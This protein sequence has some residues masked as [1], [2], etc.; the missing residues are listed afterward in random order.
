MFIAASHW[1]RKYLAS[2]GVVAACA[3]LGEA[4]HILGLANAN[5]IMIFLTAVVIVAA[6]FG[7]GPATA[8]A[9]LGVLTFDFF[10]VDPIFSF[11]PSD[12]QYF[13]DLGVMLGTGLL[14]SELTS[15]LKAQ[16]EVARQQEHRTSQLYLLTRR[17]NDLAGTHELVAGTMRHLEETYGGE[18]ALLV[19]DADGAIRPGFGASNSFVADAETEQAA[20]W[21]LERNSPAGP[22]TA[23]FVGIPALLVPMIGSRST[24][25]VLRIRPQ[26]PTR[27]LDADE[28]R[29]A[30]TSANLIALSIERDESHSAAQAAQVQ[31]QT[32]QLRNALLSSVSHDLRTPL[33]TIAVTA[34]SLLEGADKFDWRAKREAIETVVDESHR[35]AHQVDNLLDMARLDSG[36]IELKRDWHVL[37]ELVGVVLRRLRQE[38]KRRPIAVK[39]PSDLPLLWV[40]DELL[41]QVFVNLLENALQYSPPTGAIEISAGQNDD[42]VEIYIADQGSGLPPGRE[43][44][45][46]EKFVRGASVVADGQRGVGL[47]LAI[48]RSIVRAHGGDIVARNR[49]EGGAEFRISL[50]YIVQEMSQNLDDFLHPAEF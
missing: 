48:C 37:E 38:L 32:E 45:I 47:G 35:L 34:S 7:H 18:A 23:N 25:G 16:L 9:I 3:V 14:I 26:D 13:V 43:A 29:T 2:I 22:G 20:R 6:L 30:E 28:R 17:L 10:F 40:A 36:A 27:F 19:Q 39:I 50:P 4:A 49:S 5:I 31:V 12:T 1:W 8:A 46:F 11:A 15:R 21:V 41:E 33:A 24:L 44:Q 42:K